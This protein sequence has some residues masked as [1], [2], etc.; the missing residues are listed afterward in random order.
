MAGTRGIRWS[1][2]ARITALGV[3]VFVVIALSPQVV[4]QTHPLHYMWRAFN[5]SVFTAGSSPVGALI[6]FSGLVIL[7]AAARGQGL[8]VQLSDFFI[9]G[10]LFFA[11]VFTIFVWNLFEMPEET[12]S[13][14]E[15]AT[16]AKRTIVA[17][18][19]ADSLIHT[20]PFVVGKPRDLLGTGVWLDL[21]KGR[22][23]TCNTVEPN[24][25]GTMVGLALMPTLPSKEG[26]LNEGTNFS[27]KGV[28]V[29]GSNGIEAINAPKILSIIRL[30]NMFGKSDLP[31]TP[32][33]SYKF[34]YENDQIFLPVA[35][36]DSVGE[37]EAAIIEGTIKR[38]GTDLHSSTG[39]R[40]YTTIQ[41]R[42]NYRGAP[43]LDSSEHM[44]GIVCDPDRDNL[45]TA[46]PA[47]YTDERP[48]LTSTGQAQD[49]A[50]RAT[51]Y[52]Y[53][54]LIFSAPFLILWRVCFGLLV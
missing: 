53:L 14:E 40:I 8:Q 48:P 5:R 33:T 11:A 12:F 2:D 3:V 20:E 18:L 24:Q 51:V 25:P 39:A 19:P 30:G 15:V 4:Q 1:R 43:I 41:F 16:F 32:V 38:L 37:P 28:I 10:G 7:V 46:I 54:A 13:R 23:A 22:V 26:W 34:A 49:R 47:G 35:E 31:A 45:V 42:P 36:L 50:I 9:A 27:M 17:L 29:G 6:V 44:L 21:D 52:V